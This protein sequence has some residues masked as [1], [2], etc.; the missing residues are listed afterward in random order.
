MMS[1]H[2]YGTRWTVGRREF[3]ASAAGLA[4]LL[5]SR[6]HAQVAGTAPIPATL[7]AVD[8]SGKPISLSG[9]DVKDLRARLGGGVL[10]A[11]DVEY[12][13]ARRIWNGA[14]DRKPALIARCRRTTD[15]VAAV[16]F[17]HANKLLTAVRSGGH[18]I[19]GQSSVDG[20]I[21]I[22]LSPMRGIRIDA[23]A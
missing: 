15:V 19:S 17:A 12:H 10:I 7:P 11:Q 16:Q 8:W 20:G 18:S 6:A 21:M 9:A 3:V 14:F 4:A 22:D 5:A 13:S 1:F 23:K 2:P